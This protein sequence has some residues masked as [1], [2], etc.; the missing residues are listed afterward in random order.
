MFTYVPDRNCK[1]VHTEAVVAK[2]SLKA[3]KFILT[4]QV[5]SYLQNKL[6][7]T[8]E[9]ILN[10]RVGDKDKNEPFKFLYLHK[11]F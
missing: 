9:L 6:N 7:F 1:I 4:T 8:T 11:K 10:I 3:I 5:Y 2:I